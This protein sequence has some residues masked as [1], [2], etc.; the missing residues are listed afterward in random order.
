MGGRA[1]GGRRLKENPLNPTA[2]GYELPVVGVTIRKISFSA[3]TVEVEFED[4]ELGTILWILRPFTITKW[5]Q[6]WKLDPSNTESLYPILGILGEAPVAATAERGGG[7]ELSFAEQSLRVEPSPHMY[8]AW[9]FRREDGTRVRCR[10][11]G[12]LLID[13]IDSG[14][15]RGG[16]RRRGR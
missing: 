16:T 3:G 15:R 11:P 5:K 13:P 6:T 10:G 2:A 7:L 8:A 4:R 9:E 12:E 14:G 1:E